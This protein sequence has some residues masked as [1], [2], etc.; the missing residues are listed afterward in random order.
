MAGTMLGWLRYDGPYSLHHISVALRLIYIYQAVTG[1]FEK[2]YVRRKTVK[3][4]KGTKRKRTQASVSQHVSILQTQEDELPV[5]D[6]DVLLH[7]DGNTDNPE[8]LELADMQA[9]ESQEIASSDKTGDADRASHDEALVKGLNTKAI[10]QMGEEGVLIDKG[11]LDA[12][13]K[14]LPKVCL[15]SWM[16]V[17]LPLIISRFIDCRTCTSTTRQYFA[18]CGV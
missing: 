10:A 4:S 13:Q 6:E 9:L 17:D 2:N 14:V 8:E 5:A 11:Q 16:C 18:W 7:E 1:F 3:S 12:A 15:F